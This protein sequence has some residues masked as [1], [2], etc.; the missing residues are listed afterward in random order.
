[1]VSPDALQ[2]KWVG[3]ELRHALAVRGQRGQDN[4]PV[5]PL[6]LN[7]T[8]LGVLEEFFCE[9]P[10]YISVSS[11]AGGVEAAMNAILVALGKRVPA[12]VAPTPQ[13]KAEPLEELVLELTDLKFHEQEGIRRASA[14]AR[15][16]YEPAAPGQEPTH[17]LQYWRLVAPMGPIEAEELRWYLEKYAIWPSEYFRD[18]AQKVEANLVKWGQ[19]LHEVAMPPAHRENVMKAW[20]KIGDHAGL[21][22]RARVLGVFH[23]GVHLVALEV[24]T[25]W[26]EADI[27]SLA[28]ELIKTG[29]ATLNRYK[30][31]T[32]NP[33]LSP[34]L[35]W[36][37][38][39]AQRE[40]V[41]FRWI[42]AM[43]A[44]VKFLVE[45]QSQAIEVAAAL[46]VLELPNLF[47]LL[48]LVREAGDAEA[49]IDL[50]TSLYSLLQALGK[51]RLLHR[52]GQ[53]R[54]AA[55]VTLGNAWGHPQFNAAATRIEQLLLTGRLR[56]GLDGAQQLL[57]R[58]R[59]AGEEAYPNA[60]YD[61]A[62]A[63]IILARSMN[64][65]GDSEL[66]LP[67]L[68][69]ARLRFEAIAKARA[70]D[71]AEGMASVCITEQGDSLLTLG[72]LNEAAAAYEEAIHRDER[73]GAER[74][75]AVGK[76][77]LGTVR[78]EQR[79]YPEALAAY[80]D[81][82][83]RFTQ[84]DEPGTVA[85]VW[86]Q[87]GILYQHAGQVETA[88]E[89]YQKSLAIKVR[90]GDVSGQ[91]STLGQL[92]TLYDGAL[93]RPEEAVAFYQQ[94]AD[95]YV[96]IGNAAAEG[97]QRSNLANTLRKLH[98]LD[99]ARQEILRAIECDAQFGHASEP[100]KRPGPSLPL[101]RPTP[102][103][104]TA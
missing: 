6:S 30:H 98:R 29:L 100:W 17:S 93:G 67:M 62:M 24:M 71:S 22:D 68:D 16:V 84:L 39:V 48:D 95:K 3:K 21:R 99:E 60:D 18:R 72:R 33:A 20:A 79:R 82:R 1:V 40:A 70:I 74:D 55:A 7:G 11:E 73:R 2:S 13:P 66:A 14:R 26:K 88:E 58:S 104:P 57:Q 96:E 46:T 103:I 32:L 83:Q 49:T 50:A 19:L 43:S 42:E 41:T 59:T 75:V 76:V 12:D 52:V 89:A 77:Q 28:D 87:T 69:E 37:L 44:Y 56:E 4:F 34:F 47:A 23:G 53:V 94:A 90:L 45:Q 102:A 63:Y 5:I 51:P 86:H 97:R 101:S 10:I 8:R 61:L 64:M 91:A 35:R 85:V 92:G 81:A 25:E 78:K 9:E 27:A 80:A 15:L 65:S 36:S 54:D 31:L 38:D